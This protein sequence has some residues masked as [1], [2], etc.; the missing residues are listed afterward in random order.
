MHLIEI[1]HF[2]DFKSLVFIGYALSFLFN[3]DVPD[4]PWIPYHPDVQLLWAEEF[5]TSQNLIGDETQTRKREQIKKVMEDDQQHRDVLRRQFFIT[6]LSVVNC[7]SQQYF[8]LN[9]HLDEYDE[10]VRRFSSRL[11]SMS[12]GGTQV[13][14]SFYF[15]GE[16]LFSDG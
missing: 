11:M 8:K 4:A 12:S 9:D 2:S 14:I 16:K 10:T 7:V 6:S 15:C 1:C 3:K 13:F 5:N